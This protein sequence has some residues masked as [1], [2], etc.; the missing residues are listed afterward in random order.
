M[1]KYGKALVLACLLFIVAACGENAPPDRPCPDDQHWSH[2]LQ[3]MY[4]PTIIYQW[5][6]VT[7]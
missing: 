1:F 5:E 3:Y 2:E 7:Q 4:Y 6:C